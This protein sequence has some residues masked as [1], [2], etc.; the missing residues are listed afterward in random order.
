M[1]VDSAIHKLSTDIG[2]RRIQNKRKIKTKKEAKHYV[3]NGG[4]RG[5]KGPNH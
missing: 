3:S 5:V 1:H 2:T 4:G